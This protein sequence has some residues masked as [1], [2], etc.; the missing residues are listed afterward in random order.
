LASIQDRPFAQDKAIGAQALN[1]GH[2]VAD[3]KNRSAA[4]RDLGKSPHTLLLKLGIPHRQNLVDN[5]YL[6]VEMSRHSEGQTNLHSTRVSFD[7]SV[8]ELLDLGKGDNLVEPPPNFDSRHSEDRSVK[9]NIFSAGE[10]LMKACS[11]FQQAG[12]TTIDADPALAW[13]RDPAQDLQ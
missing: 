3:K 1:G 7:W 13:L 11:D 10:F 4:M 8:E 9:E 5:K 6:R 12:N 2:I